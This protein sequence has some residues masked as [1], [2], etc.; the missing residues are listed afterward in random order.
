MLCCVQLCYAGQRIALFG[1]ALYPHVHSLDS[2]S[3]WVPTKIQKVCVSVHVSGCA[4]VCVIGSVQQ[5]LWLPQ[6]VCSL[7]TRD[8]LLTNRVL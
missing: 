8:G 1:K 4:C 7:G 5:D 2:R 6:A 3:N